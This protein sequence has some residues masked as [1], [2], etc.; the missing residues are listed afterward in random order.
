MVVMVGE[1]RV[2]VLQLVMV[3][4]EQGMWEEMQEQA[5]ESMLAG[6]SEVIASTGL[7]W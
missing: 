5:A 1:G 3:L 2:M 7:S 6:A 4:V